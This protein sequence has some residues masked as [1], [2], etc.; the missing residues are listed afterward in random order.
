MNDEL[1]HFLIMIGD[2]CAAAQVAALEVEILTVDGIRH[3]GVPAAP[4]PRDD[5]DA[6]D[7]TGYAEIVI[8]GERLPLEIVVELVVRAPE[9][10]GAPQPSLSR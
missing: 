7:G 8:A 6:V 5:R 2:S 3:V 9:R 10:A 1:A 4:A